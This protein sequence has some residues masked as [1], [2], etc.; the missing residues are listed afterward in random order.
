MKGTVGV[1]STVGEGSTF[2]FSLPMLALDL[3]TKDA[4]V[5]V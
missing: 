1:E 5:S 4:P 2:S 3:R